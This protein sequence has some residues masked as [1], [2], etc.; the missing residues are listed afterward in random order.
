VKFA[1]ASQLPSYTILLHFAAAMAQVE[2]RTQQ[3]HPREEEKHEKIH[4]YSF[5]GASHEG[6]LIDVVVQSSGEY[7]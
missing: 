3:Q 4:K 1:S 7:H 5:D 6:T 2:K